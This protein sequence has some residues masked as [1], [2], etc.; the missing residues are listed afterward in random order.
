MAR[1]GAILGLGGSLAVVDQ[2]EVVPLS[3]LGLAALGR[4]ASAA[5]YATVPSAPSSA[6]RAS[7]QRDCDRSLREISACLGRSGTAASANRRSALATIAAQASAPRAIV[8]PHG[9]PGDKA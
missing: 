7:E 8:T 1:N 2:I 4:D 3:I 5:L 6:R 9:A